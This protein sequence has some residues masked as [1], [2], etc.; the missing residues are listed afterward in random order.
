MKKA[1]S[2]KNQATLR[3]ALSELD[4]EELAQLFGRVSLH[5]LKWAST[6]GEVDTTPHALLSEGCAEYR[7]TAAG[8]GQKWT[9]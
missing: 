8:A 6:G 3:R 5:K 9:L 7:E 2:K 4:N 1:I